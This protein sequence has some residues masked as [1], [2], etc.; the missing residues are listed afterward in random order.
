MRCTVKNRAEATSEKNTRQKRGRRSATMNASPT[1]R[2]GNSKRGRSRSFIKNRSR[3]STSNRPKGVINELRA[4]S[5]A[6]ARSHGSGKVPGVQGGECYARHVVSGDAGFG[7]RRARQEGR[8]YD[9]L[10]SRLPRGDLR[11]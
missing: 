9:C 6:S 1:P 4:Q 3:S 11:K 5:L 8:R 2:R 7:Q 10:R